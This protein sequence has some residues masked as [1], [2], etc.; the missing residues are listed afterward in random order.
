MI[1]KELSKALAGASV[2]CPPPARSHPHP[3]NVAHPLPLDPETESGHQTLCGFEGPEKVLEIWFRPL[4][5]SG[6][7]ACST[8]RSSSRADIARDVD[9]LSTVDVSIHD[10]EEIVD[11]ARPEHDYPTDVFQDSDGQWQYRTSGLRLV[12]RA[13]WESMLAI[14]Q[15]QVLNVIKNECA[16]AYLLSESSMFVYPNRLILKTC[17]TTTLLHAVPKIL[18]IAR[19][20]CG[21]NDVTSVFYSRKAFLFPE[22]QSWPH[23]RWGDEVAYLDEILPEDEFE[24]AGYVIG[25]VN[26]DHWCLYMATPLQLSLD[27]DGV[28]L[29]AESSSRDSDAG[30]SIVEEEDEEDEATL[31]ILMTNLDPEAMKQ[32]WRTAEELVAAKEGSPDVARQGGHRVYNSSGISDIYPTAI[33]DDYLFDPCG[34]SLNG[35]VGPYYFT[36]HVTPEAV[37]SYASFE[38]TVPV[39]RCYSPDVAARALSNGG[40]KHAAT[41]SSSSSSSSEEYESYE[42]VVSRVV[43]VFRPGTF[44]TTLFSRKTAVTAAAAAAGAADHRTDGL[45]EGNV[46]GGFRRRDRIVHC[47]GKWDL[48]FCHYD[49]GLQTPRKKV[50]KSLVR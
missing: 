41:T 23:G 39:K 25:K 37:C 5:S 7:S 47:L 20:Y 18:E 13:V 29:A 44:S 49:R 31:E 17:G 12:D 24:T 42:D 15:C 26:G 28:E 11:C 40:K 3:H 2:S 22:K 19:E 34:Y 6:K 10:V 32:F 27:L 35:L 1:M 8:S 9:N 46:G 33:I 4:N 50:V 36:I 14:V 48:V 45:L 43:D 16:D 30:S 21:L 38:T